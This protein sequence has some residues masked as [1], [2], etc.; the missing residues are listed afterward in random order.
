MLF[1]IIRAFFSQVDPSLDFRLKWYLVYY[2]VVKKKSTLSRS[3]IF[4]ILKSDFDFK[5]DRPYEN[6]KCAIGQGSLELSWS[7]LLDSSLILFFIV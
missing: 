2:F 5:V 3:S 4:W 6:N 1:N 7:R